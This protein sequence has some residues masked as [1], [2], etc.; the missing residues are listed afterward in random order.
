MEVELP[1]EEVAPGEI[2]L[3]KPGEKIS[4]DGTIIEGSAYINQAAI[5]GE[6]IPVNRSVEENVFSGTVIEAGYLM[7]R[8]EKVG[9][10]TT[11]AR[12]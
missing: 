12:I 6:S 4:I 11:F 9:D 1:P 2:V 10:D 7:I 3:V 5:T 8:A